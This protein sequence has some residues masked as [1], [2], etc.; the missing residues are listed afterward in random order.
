[1]VEVSYLDEKE[2]LRSLGPGAAAFAYIAS[3]AVDSAWQ[4]RG[5]ATALLRGAE[6][7]AGAAG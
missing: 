6:E 3:M 4:Q 1:M 5:V 2:V 7:V